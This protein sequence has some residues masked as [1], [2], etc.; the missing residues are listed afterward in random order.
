MPVGGLFPLALVLVVAAGDLLLVPLAGLHVAALTYVALGLLALWRGGVIPWKDRLPRAFGAFWIVLGCALPLAAVRASDPVEGRFEITG[1]VC[2]ALIGLGFVATARGRG[3]ERARLGWTLGLALC[4]LVALGELATDRHLWV[5][6]SYAWVASRTIVAGPFRNPNDFSIALTLMIS[7]ALGYRQAAAGIRRVAVTGLVAL[8]TLLV[9]LTESRGGL[10]A[11]TTVLAIHAIR[12]SLDRRDGRPARHRASASVPGRSGHGRRTASIRMITAG[13]LAGAALLASVTIPAIAAHNPLVR[14]MSSLTAEGTARSDH[15]RVDLIAAAWRYVRSSD[16]LGTGAASF[17]PLLAADPAPRVAVHT[18]LHQSFV[19]LLL[20]YGWLPF[21]ALVVL[22]GA[23]LIR[24][25]RR[26][27]ASPG[28][29]GTADSDIDRASAP[30][31]RLARAEGL[32]ALVTFAALGCVAATVI[33]TQI[34]WIMLAQAVASAGAVSRAC[35][36]AARSRAP[37]PAVPTDQ[38][39]GT[40]ALRRSARRLS[41]PVSGS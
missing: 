41:A 22:L 4:C 37:A 21:I 5:P 14:V 30:H 10:L 7:G 18:W 29:D 25:C 15:L 40:P 34:W 9:A 33:D 3:L 35:A 6:D 12:A 38:T 28:R 36:T 23:I 1:I 24:L 13:L 26:L 11:L 32:A 2:A 17:E 16:G 27:P 8:G 20:Q 19:E 31:V 39:P